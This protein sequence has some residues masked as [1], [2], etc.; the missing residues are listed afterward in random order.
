M[1]KKALEEILEEK[2]E[3]LKTWLDH[4]KKA[5]DVAP[6]VR[7]NLEWTEWELKA[8]RDYPDKAN[9]TFAPLED[10]FR[11]DLE[12][13]RES[14]PMM[15]DYDL[16]L[17]TDSTAVSTPGV[18]HVYGYVSN[19]VRL[20]TPEAIEY[21]ERYTTEYQKLQESQGR[22][23]DVRKLVEKLKQPNLLERFDKAEKAYMLLKV[24]TGE[25]STVA[26]LLRN[27]LDGMKGQLFEFARK[28]LQ[29]NMTWKIMADRLAKGG[30]GSTECSVIIDEESK[31]SML[32]DRLSTIAK[33]REGKLLRDIED[34]WAIVLDHIYAVLSL[35]NV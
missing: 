23:I 17:V 8:I 16:I 28:N 1:N 6:Y 31:Y 35:V 18:S 26:L 34:I 3:L 12:F 15:P 21:A 25:R 27:L 9:I 24:G 7:K 5:Q 33:D 19:A 13:S 32:I 29:E 4:H 10:T 20:G 22:A 30:P 14:L 2:H 11:R